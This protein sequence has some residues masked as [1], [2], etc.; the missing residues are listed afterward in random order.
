MTHTKKFIS[1]MLIAVLMLSIVPFGATEQVETPAPVEQAAPTEAPPVPTEVPAPVTTEA[2]TEVPAPTEAPPAPT[3]APT[4]APAPTD[5][6]AP[7]ATEAPT[8]EPA[9]TEQ[10]PTEEPTTAPTEQPTQEPLPSPTEQANITDKTGWEYA[11][12]GVAVNP[13]GYIGLGNSFEVFLSYYDPGGT[14][15]YTFAYYIYKGNTVVQK[16]AYSNNTS[17]MYTPKTT[18]TYHAVVFIK[19]EKG[20]IRTLTSRRINVFEKPNPINVEG[21]ISAQKL[22]LGDSC[23][24]EIVSSGGDRSKP[25]MHTY[26][27]YRNN[28]LEEKF[29]YKQADKLYSFEAIYT[30]TIMYTPK[31]PGKYKFTAFAKDNA[32]NAKSYTTDEILVSSSP[33]YL[34]TSINKTNLS[35][36]EVANI[37]AEASGG[38][39]K[40]LYA[41]YVYKDNVI[42]YKGKYIANAQFKYIPQSIGRYKVLAFV[43]DNIGTIKTDTTQEFFVASTPLSIDFYA[44]GNSHNIVG[45][46]NSEGGVP[47]YKYAYYIY[48]NN[49]IVE[50]TAYTD[51]E[52]DNT[53]AYYHNFIYV[54]K[55]SGTYK[56]TAFVKDAKGTIKTATFGELEF[57]GDLKFMEAP[58]IPSNIDLGNV[59]DVYT[60]VRYGEGFYQY[61]YYIYKDNA[62]LQKFPYTTNKNFTYTPTSTGVYKILVFVKDASGNIAYEMSDNCTVNAASTLSLYDLLIRTKFA[63]PNEQ[64]E[65]ET[66]A[67][68]GVKPYQYAYYIYHNNNIIKKTAYSQY[69]GIYTFIPTSIGDYKVKAFVKDATGAIVYGTSKNCVVSYNPPSGYQEMTVKLE[70]KQLKPSKLRLDCRV[71]EGGGIYPF[72][73]AYYI[74]KDGVRI[75]VIPYSKYSRT[76]HNILESGNYKV[77][78]FVKDKVGKIKTDTIDG[79]VVNLPVDNPTVTM[80]NFNSTSALVGRKVD[81]RLK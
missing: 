78:A 57:N 10:T 74:Y 27:V 20:E 3:E 12:Q 61:A 36:G 56:I 71:Y 31:R 39:G 14:G 51:G 49:R 22:A 16:T 40:Y 35:L 48:K 45:Y 65:L 19:N 69:D 55:N 50:K 29:P 63:L 32:G 46:V 58:R 11:P 70:V 42:I 2:L 21:H 77:I 8:E 9:P 59:I 37:N 13:P 80:F 18:G 23:D 34:H 5:P 76:Y 24:I 25:H 17:Y 6:P 43:K 33:L 62:L 44:Y 4:E 53:Y 60:R 41:Y 30:S 26:Y 67:R 7:V 79:I 64:I 72:Q 47:P 38:S 15:K 75:R 81:I 28:V 73:Y 1:I 52:I 54:P 66:F 68:G